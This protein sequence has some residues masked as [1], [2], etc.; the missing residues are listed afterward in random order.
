MKKRIGWLCVSMMIATMLL[1]ATLVALTPIPLRAE[2]LPRPQAPRAPQAPLQQTHPTPTYMISDS[3]S[4]GVT[5]EWI[6]I[7]GS[8]APIDLWGDNAG[9]DPVNI[10]FNFPF[11]DNVYDSFRVSTNGYIYFDGSADDGNQIPNLID[12]EYGPTSPP[13]NFIAPF[14]ADLFMHPRVS[15][16][17]VERQVNPA[18]PSSSLSIFNGAAA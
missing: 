2:A 14:G 15:Q 12:G 9:S 3:V 11:F 10:G 17:Y 6:E 7:S 5:Y 8:G 13:E 18:G 4:G 1:S 16:V